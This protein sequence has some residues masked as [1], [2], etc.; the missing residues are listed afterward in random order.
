MTVVGSAIVGGEMSAKGLTQAVLVE[1][2]LMR[3]EREQK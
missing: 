1:G 2:G 3:G